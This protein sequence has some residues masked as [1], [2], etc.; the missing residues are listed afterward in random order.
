MVIFPPP[1]P[2]SCT[3]RADRLTPAA[4]PARPAH[5]VRSGP[6]GVY[7]TRESGV[8]GDEGTLPER[9]TT[10]PA[11]VQCSIIIM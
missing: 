4:R 10:P 2:R 8:Y 3:V 1:P 11:P 7:S 9:A 6:S 5:P